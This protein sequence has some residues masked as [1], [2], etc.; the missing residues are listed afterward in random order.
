MLTKLVVMVALTELTKLL[1]MV[2]L[3]ETL[4][5]LYRLSPLVPMLTKLHSVVA[6]AVK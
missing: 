6:L 1:V 2:A 5:V 4:P 3:K